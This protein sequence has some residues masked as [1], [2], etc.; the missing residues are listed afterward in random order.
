MK[1]KK[2]KPTWNDIEGVWE[3]LGFFLDKFIKHFW[4]FMA[5]LLAVFLIV[6]GFKCDLKNL[7]FTKEQIKIKD[8]KHE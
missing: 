5:L 2:D 7:I 1:K 6:G 4:K 3:A 8:V